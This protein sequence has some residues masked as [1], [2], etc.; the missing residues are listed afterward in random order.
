MHMY[1]SIDTIP[2]EH[3]PYKIAKYFSDNNE[4]NIVGYQYQ[5]NMNL[6]W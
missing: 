5:R 3:Q 6:I 2:T 1:K 4:N